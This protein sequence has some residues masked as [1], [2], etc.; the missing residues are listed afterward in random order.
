MRTEEVNIFKFSELSETAKDKARE[1]Y[2]NTSVNDEWWDCVY[3]DAKTIAALMGF[4][5]DKIYFSGF[6]SQGDGACFDASFK[7]AKGCV[8]AVKSHAPMDAEL[9]VI[10]KEW[11]RIQSVNFY[12]VTGTVKQSG[13]YQHSGCTS[14]DIERD[15]QWAS[16]DLESDVKDCVRSFMDWIYCEL[17]KEYENE[18]S[19]ESVDSN[20]LANEYEFTEDGEIY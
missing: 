5:I 4:D 9:H 2:R 20:I 3:D 15:G 18:N 8:K 14:F 7:Y 12:K 19:N 1:W 17:E 10:A 13:H 16:D 11:H 6:W